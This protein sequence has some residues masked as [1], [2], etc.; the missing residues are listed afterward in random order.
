MIVLFTQYFVIEPSFFQG[1]TYKRIQPN[2]EINSSE[3][4]KFWAAEEEKEKLRQDEERNK[5]QHE[6]KTIENE[7]LLREVKRTKIQVCFFIYVLMAFYVFIKDADRIRR[8]SVIEEKKPKI[9]PELIKTEPEIIK[10]EPIE[11]IKTEVVK[12]GLVTEESDKLIE[13]NNVED[14]FG[15]RAEALYDYQAGNLQ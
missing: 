10:I 9:E 3:R 5:K 2:L 14:D 12:P 1:T 4:D 11:E 8:D 13:Q 15:I 7:R 6:Q